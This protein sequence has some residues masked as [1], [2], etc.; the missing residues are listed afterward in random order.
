MIRAATPD[1]IPAA[2]ALGEAMHRESRFHTLR[3]NPAKVCGLM[4]WCIANDDALFVV[5][6]RGGEIVGGFLGGCE[7]HWCSDDLVAYDF[8]LFVAPEHRG[9]STGVRLLQHFIAWAS[10]KGARDITAGVTTGVNLDGATRLYQSLGFRHVGHVFSH[11]GT[12][13]HA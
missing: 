9:G 7:S 5:E 10:A 8:A 11:E 12:A 4:D 6:D 1:D 3:W 2:I 13:P